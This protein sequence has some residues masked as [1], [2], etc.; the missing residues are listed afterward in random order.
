MSVVLPTLDAGVVAR[1]VAG[2]ENSLM[3]YYR[4]E[5]D[6]LLSADAETPGPELAHFRSRVAHKA[7]LDTWYARARFQNPIAFSAFLEEAVHWESDNQRRRHA[8]S[9]RRAGEASRRGLHRR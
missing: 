3:A 8:A 7:M 4:Q 2:D 1:F 5:Y 6:S 9:R